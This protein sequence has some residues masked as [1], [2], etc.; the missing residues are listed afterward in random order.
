[1]CPACLKKM[2]EIDRLKHQLEKSRQRVS[3][4][5]K[6]LGQRARSSGESPFGANGSSATIPIKKNSEEDKR[7]LK[8]GAKHG[9]L[10]HGRK[11]PEVSGPVETLFAPAVCPA[12]GGA[13]KLR[14]SESRHVRDHIPEQ[15]IDRH[16]TVQTCE[17]GSCGKL[18]EANVPGVMP[19][20]KYSNQ[21]IADAAC[22]HYLDGRTQGD[23][24]RRFD[25]GLG[26][27]N[28]SMQNLA[29]LLNPCMDILI[30][31]FMANPVRFGDETGYRE[32]GVG[33]YAWLL[34]T[35]DVSL[36]LIGRSRAG[37][38]PLSLISPFIA[39]DDSLQHGTLNVDR[40]SAYNQ[41]PFMLQYCYAH[42]KRDA[43]KLETD[44]PKIKEAKDFAAALVKQLSMAMHLHGDK[45]LSDTQY[46]AKAEEI[47]AEIIRICDSEAKHPAVQNLQNIFRKNQHRMYHWAHDRRVPP[48]NNYSERSL[49]PLVI[50]R[51]LSFGTQ[52][53]KGSQTR[54]I[55][56]S[57]LHSLKK[58]GHDPA[59]RIHQA[60]NLKTQNSEFDLAR[61]LFPEVKEH[62]PLR[63]APDEGVHVGIKLTSANIA[64]AILAN[65]A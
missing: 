11:T 31:Q 27:L 12:C 9:H 22:E 54:E 17:C 49:R 32:N 37:D 24:A 36:F 48:D 55:L 60:L 26:A 14:K 34:S 40:Y 42:L 19:R 53:A 6:R 39:A 25:I 33:K 8:G 46:Y 18:I 13:T 2:C 28:K 58:Q 1:M 3:D 63:T 10:G 15:I 43:E 30:R 56:M 44:F 4:L 21:Y 57:V 47:K 16:F 29:V 61:F 7:K 64:G 5:E 20:A 41:M 59:A 65:T 35:L 45:Q 52:S 23:V 38:V 62:P 51:K 50:S